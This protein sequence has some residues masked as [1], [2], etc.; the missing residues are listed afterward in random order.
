[1]MTIIKIE[2]YENGAHANQ[3]I[4]SVI[5]VPDEWALVPEDMLPLESFPFGDAE[6][7]EIDGVM[8]VTKWT[9]GKLPD[10][11]PT[12]PPEPTQLDRVEAQ[13]LYTAM[14]TDTLLESEG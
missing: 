2:P 10:P 6:V 12:P 8:T 5:P 13:A 1:M 4:Y 9:P 11:E 3:T 14:L 7:E